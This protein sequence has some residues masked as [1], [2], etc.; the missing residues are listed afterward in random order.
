MMNQTQFHEDSYTY[1]KW[2]S[3][4]FHDELNTNLFKPEYEDD[5]DI[6]H[7]YD[8]YDY[9]N[10]NIHDEELPIDYYEN[11]MFDEPPNI[12]TY[13]DEDNEEFYDSFDYM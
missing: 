11:G 6:E 13:L 7:E 10:P 3:A 5:M 4:N 2:L 9:L 1:T 8:P 12:E